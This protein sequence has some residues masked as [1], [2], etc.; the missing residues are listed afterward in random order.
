ML[1]E[2][3]RADC[4]ILFDYDAF[5]RWSIPVTIGRQASGNSNGAGGPG[6]V[7]HEADSLDV[8]QPTHDQLKAVPV[9]WILEIVPTSYTYQNLQDKWVKKWR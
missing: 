4:G 1:Q 3:V 8:V 9:W 2:I 6:T 5:S 7:N